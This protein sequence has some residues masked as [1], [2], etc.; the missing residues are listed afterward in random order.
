[1][2]VV[3]A[4][5]QSITEKRKKDRERQARR[6]AQLKQANAPQTHDVERAVTE[7]VGFQF[8]K[9]T[10]EASREDAEAFIIPLTVTIEMI[11][12]DRLEFDRDETRKAIKRLLRHRP[13][14]LDPDFIPSLNPRDSIQRR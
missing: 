11:L 10:M 6:R 5:K 14:H 2:E 4:E 7:A 12:V 3:L 8:K 1:M 9:W 13:G